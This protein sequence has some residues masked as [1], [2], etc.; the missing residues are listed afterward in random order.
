M[1]TCS[2]Y[3]EKFTWR[4]EDFS[5]KNGMKLKSKYFK[6]RGYTWRILV[7]PL[8]KDVDHFTFYLMVADSL[9][10]Y[11]WNRDTFF[12]LVLVNQLDK[13]KSIV[14]ETQQK[15]NGGYRCWGSFFLSLKDFNDH[16]QGYLVRDTCIIEAHICVSNFTPKI[17]DISSMNPNSTDQSSDVRETVCPRT[18]GSTSSPRASGSTFSPRTSSSDLTL[19]ELLDLENLKPEEKCFIPLLD[20]ICTWRLSLIESLMKKTPLFRQWAFT[21]LGQVLYFLK[22]KKVKDMNEHDIEKIRSLWEELEKSSELDLSW[23]EPYVQSALGVKPYMERAKKLKKLKDKVVALDIKMKKLRDELSASQA[24]YEVARK[25][26]SE[27]RNG[28]QEMNIN[29]PIGYTML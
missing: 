28:F 29:A 4:I 5:T 19:R 17:H 27:V 22:T 15:F 23:L 9:P 14:K 21:S 26:L 2:E 12:K 18:S 11:G 25:G 13:N 1:G 10:P 24:Q 20:E 16:K 7:H 3:F 8:R 6:I